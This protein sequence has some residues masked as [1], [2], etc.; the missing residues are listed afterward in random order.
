MAS[1][2]FVF[3]I[4][5]R[6]PNADFQGYEYPLWQQGLQDTRWYRVGGRP[7]RARR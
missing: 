5:K 6:H 1:D 3:S 4:V 7:Y 2:Q